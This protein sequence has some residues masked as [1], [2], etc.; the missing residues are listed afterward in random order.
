MPALRFLDL[1]LEAITPTFSGGADKK[2]EIRPPSFR[3]LSRYWL[4][5]LLGGFFGDDPPKVRSLENAIFGHAHRASMVAFRSGSEVETALFDMDRDDFPGIGYLFY[6]IYQNRRDGILAQQRFRVRIQTRPF[7]P[8]ELIVDEQKL[9]VD[10]GWR[11]TLG[12]TWLLIWLGGVGARVR[13][14]GGSLYAKALPAEWPRSLPS[15][16]CESNDPVAYATEIGAKLSQ[17][18]GAF[19]WTPAAALPKTPSANLLHPQACSIFILNKTYPTWH[20]ALNEVGAAFRDFRSRQPDDYVAVKNFLK[21]LSKGVNQV[22]RAIFGLPLTFFFSSLYR[23]L[24][25][26]GVPER[27]ARARATATLGP[28]RGLGRASPLWFR[29]V[30]LPGSPPSYTLQMTLFHTRFLMDDVMTLRPRDRSL[31]R[32]DV[33][34]PTDYGY[35]HEWFDYVGKRVAPLL[36]VSFH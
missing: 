26:Q 35:L 4:R 28:R 32:I 13:R 16:L 17:L 14:G 36:P 5:A 7:P 15:P 12:T 2:A 31:H 19:G 22:K 10:L 24:R 34:M 20:E 6:S 1:E 8:P 18:R 9:D 3:G 33:P 30:R 23:Q 29:V 25:D 27:E 11:L 21:G